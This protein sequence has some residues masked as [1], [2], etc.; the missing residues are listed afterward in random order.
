MLFVS[1]EPKR[2]TTRRQLRFAFTLV[3][4]LVVISIIGILAAM[5]LPAVNSAREGARS[6]QCK[7]NLRTFGVTMS[8]RATQPDGQFCTG[9]MDWVRDGVPTE[10]GWVADAV[11]RSTLASELR[12]PSNTATSTKAIE[13]LLTL[14][15]AAIMDDDCVKMLG[16]DMRTNDLGEEVRNI[17]RS[18][19]EGP[20][21]SGFMA[22]GSPDRAKLVATKVL[23]NGYNTNYA[24]TWFL[25][26]SEFQLDENGN[27]KKVSATCLDDDPRGKNVTRGP[28]T[29]KSL[30]SSRAAGN[31]VPLLCD[32]SAGGTLTH[33]VPEFLGAG[34]LYV[35]SMV[36][37]PVLAKPSTDFS[38]LNVFDVPMFPAP[39]PKEGN[40]G[41]LKVWSR[42]VMQ[43]YR[44]M[45]THHKGTCNVLMADGSIKSLVDTNND[46]FINNGFEV[47]S[48]FTSADVEAS[49][50]ELASYY[51]L[52]TRGGK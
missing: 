16:E 45:S 23:E 50:L 51:N 14:E 47:G 39:T 11:K 1:S 42:H 32:A 22:V 6:T 7:N 34:D 36:G 41:W 33:A 30:D 13:Q 17:A 21:G 26:R 37:L 10:I 12:C 31:T 38:S 8:S 19:K 28:L 44:G 27:P 20:S 52:Q 35:V 2:K 3:E 40:M 43:D 48:E 49:P 4:L 29:I 9:N 46:Q 18:I 15:D 24:P 5:L 25:L